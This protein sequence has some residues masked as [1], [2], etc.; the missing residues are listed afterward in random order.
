MRNYYYYYSILVPSLAYFQLLD[1]KYFLFFC[2][3]REYCA[4]TF[5]LL[6]SR[7]FFVVVILP[8]LIG[9]KPELTHSV[10]LLLSKLTYDVTDTCNAIQCRLVHRLL[11]K[12][13]QSTLVFSKSKGLSETLRDIRIST[14]QICR[15]DE[16]T[17]RTTKFHK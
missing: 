17:N 15:I 3:K 9:A 11:K 5:L 12:V 16:N 13:I 7:T 6:L 14:Y 1:N 2:P 8:I 10:Y 4:S